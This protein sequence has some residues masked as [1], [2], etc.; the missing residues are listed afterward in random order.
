MSRRNHGERILNCSK[1]RSG[2]ARMGSNRPATQCTGLHL[3]DFHRCGLFQVAGR[4]EDDTDV[5]QLVSLDG[6]GLYELAAI[7]NN[8]GVNLFVPLRIAGFVYTTRQSYIYVR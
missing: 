3:A 1:P 6:V 8:L 4:G 7:L 5:V 2:C